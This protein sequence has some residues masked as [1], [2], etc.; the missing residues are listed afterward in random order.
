MLPAIMKEIKATQLS[1]K[2]LCYQLDHTEACVQLVMCLQRGVKGRIIFDEKFFYGSSCARQCPRVQEL[3][4]AGC[5]MKICKPRAG[6]FSCMHAKT[7]L[8]DDQ[9]AFTG[10]ANLTHNGMEN[11]VENLWRVTSSSAI[12]DYSKFFDLLWE[13][14][15][16]SCAITDVGEG[17]IAEMVRRHGLRRENKE[18]KPKERSASRSLSVELDEEALD[19]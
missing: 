3:Y 2:G 10:S 4:Q 19:Q 1:F 5:E 11:N 16:R 13:D 9:V 6:N 7:W 14:S 17:Q 8:F 18:S 15:V 12:T